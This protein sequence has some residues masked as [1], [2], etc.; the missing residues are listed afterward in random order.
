MERQMASLDVLQQSTGMA[1]AVVKRLLQPEGME[2]QMA[3]LDVLQQ[4]TGMATAVVVGSS[5]GNMQASES[6]NRKRNRDLIQTQAHNHHNEPVTL[7]NHSRG[8]QT[9]PTRSSNTLAGDHHRRR[10]ETARDRARTTVNV[11]SPER[12]P[13]SSTKGARTTRSKVGYTPSR[14]PPCTKIDTHCSGGNHR[15]SRSLKSSRREKRERDYHSLLHR[16]A[17]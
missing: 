16:H 1:T 6:F 4:S 10:T 12:T 15:T 9:T 3:S 14:G 8:N 17:A 7:L 13:D 5:M 2:R 11:S